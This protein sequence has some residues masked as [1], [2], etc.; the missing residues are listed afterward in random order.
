MAY[1][2]DNYENQRLTPKQEKFCQEIAKG[3]SQYEA[4]ITAYPK[5]KEWNRDGVDVQ[6]NK[7]MNNIKIVLR[8]NQLRQ[9]EEEKVKWTRQR[10]LKTIN[11]MLERNE[12]DMERKDQIYNEMMAQKLQEL[13]EWIAIKNVPNVDI[14][15]VEAKIKEITAE[16]QNIGLRRRA[17][18]VNNNGIIRAVQTLN[19][20]F[21]FDITKVEIAQEDT[22]REEME[23]LSVEDL[24]AL[25]NINKKEK[26][27]KIN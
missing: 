9:P 1:N 5:A 25:I 27:W 24:K 12:M 18:S 14:K 26:Q 10:A 16:I 20:M 11:K 2:K 7:L 21:G 4:Y 8:L 15:G 22:E 6:A 13:Q 19:R 3:K 23:K 17:D